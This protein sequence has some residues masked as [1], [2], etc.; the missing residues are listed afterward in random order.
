ML[1]R[2]A[3][4]DFLYITDATNAISKCFNNYKIIGNIVNIGSG[5]KISIKKLILK[6]VKEIGLGKPIFGV[7][8]M[9]SD[10][11]KNLVIQVFKS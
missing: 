10:E 2:Y 5:Y 3:S 6:I 11:P 8:G 7:L 9:R 4:K 1:K